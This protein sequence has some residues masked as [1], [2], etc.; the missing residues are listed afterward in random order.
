MTKNK[1]RRFTFVTTDHVSPP[2]LI[3]AGTAAQLLGELRRVLYTPA[4]MAQEFSEK[5]WAGSVLAFPQNGFCVIPEALQLAY[6]TFQPS[7]RVLS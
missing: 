5:L 1:K 7:D 3:E 2:V 4:D 6:Y